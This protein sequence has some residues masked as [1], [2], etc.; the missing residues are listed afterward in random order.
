MRAIQVLARIQGRLGVKLSLEKLFSQPTSEC[1]IVFSRLATNEADDVIRAETALAKE[2]GYGSARQAD[3][4]RD[5]RSGLKVRRQCRDA[6]GGSP[7]HSG[8]TTVTGV[9]ALMV[10]KFVATTEISLLITPVD[11]D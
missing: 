2:R 11:H 1:R 10:T 5:R 4:H 3:S 7:W 8:V 6:G 9:D